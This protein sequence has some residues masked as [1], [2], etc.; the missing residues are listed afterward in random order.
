MVF[1]L[2][3]LL[4]AAACSPAKNP[5]SRTGSTPA[6]EGGTPGQDV[7]DVPPARG[8]QGLDGL[9]GA[10]QGGIP[11]G[12]DMDAAAAGLAVAAAAPDLNGFLG[13]VKDV[14]A[15]SYSVSYRVKAPSLKLPG[16]VFA[17]FVHTPRQSKVGLQAA[18][19][20]YEQITTPSGRVDCVQ[21]GAWACKKGAATAKSTVGPEMLFGG[22]VLVAQAPGA[23]KMRT[24]ETSIV[25]VPVR[26]FR[27]E[28]IGGAK[29]GE[30]SSTSLSTIEVC[31]TGEG[32]P[33]KSVLPGITLDGVWYRPSATTS[34]FA[35]PARVQT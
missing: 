17:T 32:V 4:T 1:V 9:A 13:L 18:G 26:C 28:P 20:A 34:E 14:Q 5:V 33:L 10:L 16:D 21:S 11:G 3:A 27:G 19:I 30:K 23:F 24:Y 25:G 29:T 31:V 22:L 15:K 6:P 8:A 7:L 35:P 2:L 12:G